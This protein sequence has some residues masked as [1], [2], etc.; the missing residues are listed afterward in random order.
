M[1]DVADFFASNTFSEYR[2]GLEAKQ[3]LA[4]AII[5]RIDGVAKTVNGVS[6]TIAAFM[7]GM[8]GR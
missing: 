6:R 8:R 2:K 3:K 5:E 7:K 4:L 1:S